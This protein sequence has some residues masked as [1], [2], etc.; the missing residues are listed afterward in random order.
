MITKKHL[1]ETI[2]KLIL[3]DKIERAEKDVWKGR[4]YY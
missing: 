3:L 4:N 2:K 1:K